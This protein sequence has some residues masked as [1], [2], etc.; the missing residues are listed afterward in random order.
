MLL[1]STGFGSV[2]CFLHDSDITSISLRLI[3]SRGTVKEY[4]SILDTH[5]EVVNKEVVRNE[6]VNEEFVNKEVVQNEVVQNE[7]VNE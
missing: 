6:L 2:S 7:V 5:K 3:L 4:N 1:N